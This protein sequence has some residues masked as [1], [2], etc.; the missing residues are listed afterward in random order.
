MIKTIFVLSFLLFYFAIYSQAPSIQWDKTIGGD[1]TDFFRDM[2]P[3]HDGGYILAGSSSSGISGDK[4]EDKTGYWIVKIDDEGNKIWDKT[5]G[6]I[7]FSAYLVKIIATPDGGYLVGGYN[8]YRTAHE[9][10]SEPSKGGADYWI[11][12]IDASGT[13]LW[14]KTLGSSASDIL[15]SLV[16]SADGGYLIGG[17]S[18]GGPSGDKTQASRGGDDYWI[19]KIDEKGN[20]IWDKTYGGNGPNPE[21]SLQ[22]MVALEDGGY[23]LGG[24]SASNKSFDKTEDNKGY[25]DY[26]VIRI[27]QDGNK[28][29][30]KTIGGNSQ[31]N[32]TDISIIAGGYILAGESAS[33]ISGDKTEVSRGSYDYWIVKLDVDGNVLID[34]TLGGNY[35]DE[36]KS[37]QPLYNGGYLLGGGSA[38]GMSGEKSNDHK[39]YSDYWVIKVDDEG[40]K[41]WDKTVGSGIEGRSTINYLSSVLSTPDG[42]YLL[43]GYTDSNTSF[44]KSEDSKG[45]HDYWIVKLK[46]DYSNIHITSFS[47]NIQDENVALLPENHEVQVQLDYSTN[48]SNLIPNIEVPENSTI[49]PASGIAQDFTKPV[50]YTVT[51]EDGTSQVWAVNVSRR[52]NY[53]T[54]RINFQPDSVSNPEDYLLDTGQPFGSKANGLT[55]G[56]IDINSKTPLNLS[57]NTRTRNFDNLNIVQ[58]TFIHMQYNS[59]GGLAGVNKEGM[60]EIEIPNG[61]Y[62]VTVEVGDGGVDQL[63]TIPS[64]SINIEGK[65]VIS[66]FVPKG[67]AGALTRFTSSST[68]TSVHDNRLTVDAAGGFNTKIN[69][70]TIRSIDEFPLINDQKFSVWEYQDTGTIVGKI[71]A[72]DVNSNNL[73]YSIASGNL[74]EAFTIDENTG[75]I[76]TNAQLINIYNPEYNLKIE[77]SNGLG[78]SSATVQIYVTQLSIKPIQVNFSPSSLTPPQNYIVDS[79]LPYGYKDAGYSYGWLKEDGKTPFDFVLNTRNRNYSSIDDLHNTFIHMQYDD[80]GG[81]NGVKQ[82]GIWEISLPNGAYTVSVGVGDADEDK[83]GDTPHHTINAEEIN[84]IDNFISTGKIGSSSRFKT[85]TNVIQ[86]KDGVLTIDA[87]GGFNTKIDYIIITPYIAKELPPEIVW[88]K[89]LGGTGIDE[90]TVIYPAVDGGYLL[91]GIS[92]STKSGSKEAENLGGSDYWLVKIDEDGTKLWEKTIG[93]GN[94]DLLYAITDTP[95]GGYLLAG[96]TWSFT[97][98]GEIALWVVKVDVKGEEIWQKTYFS[99]ADV[100]RGNNIQASVLRTPDGGYILG[101][102]YEDDKYSGG[103]NYRIK[104]IDGDGNEIWNKEIFDQE[105]GFEDLRTV[106]ATKDGGY[107]IGGTKE[108]DEPDKGY[109]DFFV[110]KITETGNLSWSKIIGGDDTDVLSSMIALDDGGYLLCGWSSS[111]KSYDK[112]ENSKGAGDYWVIKVDNSGNKLWDKTIG[113]IYGDYLSAVKQTADGGFILAGTSGSMSSGDKSEDSYSWDYWIVKINGNGTVLWDKTIMADGSD[114]LASLI[115]TNDGGF[116]LGGSS[117][118]QSSGDKT[119]DSWGRNDYWFV[120]LGSPT[121]ETDIASFAF[122]EQNDEALIDGATSTI[123]IPVK[124]GA[125]VTSL[126]PIIEIAGAGAII[127]PASGEIQDFSNPITYTVKAANGVTRNWTVNVEIAKNQFEAHI[128]FQDEVTVPPLGYLTDSGEAFGVRKDSFSYGWEDFISHS[129]LDL[130]G[131]GRNRNLAALSVK[132]NTLIHMQ[133]NDAGSDTGIKKEG[134]WEV[135]VPNGTYEITVSVGDGIID[136]AGTVSSHTINVEGSNLISSFTPTGGQASNTRFNSATKIINVSDGL[137]TVDAEGGFN[138]KI[139]AIDIIAIDDYP[140]IKDQIFSVWEK[141]PA[142]FIGSVVGTNLQEDVEFSISGGNYN[143]AFNIDKNSGELFTNEALD[144]NIKQEYNLEVAASNSFHTNKAA[145]TIK[146]RELEN[147]TLK[148]N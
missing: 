91:G 129:P 78:S 108:Y 40:T 138:T 58:N 17:T 147:D 144:Y 46:P 69:S 125:D 89:T 16:N 134:I 117:Y 13:K 120:R 34:K 87:F 81:L 84:I 145:V 121:E 6:G 70:L 20:K 94:D 21:D 60:W 48:I 83:P 61:D 100:D 26:W 130:T 2:V 107:L 71:V 36:L 42:G 95:E 114:E 73:K 64:H 23:L 142:T 132:Q 55:Y 31:D 127:V 67:N 32:I 128:N 43:G 74:N 133:Y 52:R 136:G 22:T 44:D 113:G 12:K 148:I 116:L 88:E 45:R 47:F 24:N 8:G 35:T 63:G 103:F 10:K 143:T 4:T 41:E 38:S 9:D 140:V 53:F 14:D 19:I 66:S 109:Y 93:G 122:S 33:D 30:D 15:T 75:E 54:T 97:L 62:E 76:K 5:L 82:E 77:A 139:N 49:E 135:S 39:G 59:V 105:L 126:S 115:L 111:N 119:E 28:I 7:D 25:G 29:W 123:T 72:Q 11:V 56:W 106:I 92:S 146:V 141:S 98:P 18:S 90:L 37:I 131:N 65:P 101:G 68:T 137:L 80:V 85:A 104:K 110:V 96:Y 102:T 57:A 51:A 86:V 124:Y 112:S 3:A 79:G 27:D 50:L 118:S 99:N 1:D